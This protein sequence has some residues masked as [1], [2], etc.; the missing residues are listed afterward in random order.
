MNT[1]VVR[2]C[3]K[4]KVGK[5]IKML[6]NTEVNDTNLI[7]DGNRMLIPPATNPMNVCNFSKRELKDLGQIVKKELR[8]KQMPGKQ[9]RDEILYLKR[10]GGGRGLKSI[11]FVYKKTRL[12]VARYMLN[13]TNRW[14]QAAWIR[15]TIKVKNAVVTEARTT[16]E[17]V[18]FRMKFEKSAIQH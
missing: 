4:S 15:K 6:V 7:S 2:K 9:A 8:S 1:K 18:G 14:I 13:L 5:K 16:M 17:E 10:E 11:Q 3:V 12:R